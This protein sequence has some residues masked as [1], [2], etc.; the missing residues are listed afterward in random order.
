LVGRCNPHGAN[1][2]DVSVSSLSKSQAEA[3]HDVFL[4]CLT[5]KEC[6]A[7]GGVTVRGFA[8]CANPF[9]LPSSLTKA[10]EEVRPAVVHLHSVYLPQNIRLA[11]HARHKAIAYVVSPHGGLSPLVLQRNKG[12]KEAFHYLF[13]YSF[14]AG[15]AFIHA[16]SE[17]EVDH[18]RLNDIRRPIV[19][20]P[21]GING[22][23]LPEPNTL[24]GTYL[25]RLYAHTKGK[26][27]F[28]LICR[29][30]PG[31]K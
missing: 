27:I 6:L 2:V 8:P 29:V 17:V 10:I 14:W 12:V 11:S 1:G 20:A 25:G 30:D 22:T 3:G 7:I 9:R 16:L 13:A 15:A 24:D 31:F 18:V 21:N 26:K 23:E 5:Q 19:V 4:F 28:M